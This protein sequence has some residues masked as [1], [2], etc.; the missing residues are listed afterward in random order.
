MKPMISTENKVL[1]AMLAIIDPV[2]DIDGD[3]TEYALISDL[4]AYTSFFLPRN[5]D[6]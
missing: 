5:P 2:E 1:K 6:S 3:S 4:I